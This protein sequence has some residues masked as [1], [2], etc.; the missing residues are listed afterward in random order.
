MTLN[1]STIFLKRILTCC[2]G[3]LLCSAVTLALFSVYYFFKLQV[4]VY[5]ES[6]GIQSVPK[7]LT[8]AACLHTLQMEYMMSSSF[9]P[10]RLSEVHPNADLL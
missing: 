7:E 1:H 4:V 9:T 5:D 10:E 8:S 3:L 2:Q 6:W